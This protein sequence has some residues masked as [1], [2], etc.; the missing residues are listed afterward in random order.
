VILATAATC[1]AC[2]TEVGY[3]EL[4]VPPLRVAFVQAS[5]GVDPFGRP[6]TD[7][8]DVGASP[9][10]LTTTRIELG[11]DRFLL[12]GSV[13]R[14]AVCLRS[15]PEPVVAYE[16]CTNAETLRPS[17]DPVRRIARFHLGDADERLAPDTLYT[18]TVFAAGSG[19]RPGFRALDGTPLDADLVFRFRTAAEDPARAVEAPDQESGYCPDEA[20]VRRCASIPLCLARCSKGAREVLRTRCSSSSCHGASGVTEPAM[21]LVLGDDEG[22]RATAIGQVAHQTKLGSDAAMPEASPTRFGA[23]M[24]I[25]APRDPGSSYLLYKVLLAADLHGQ[26]APLASGE[27]ERLTSFVVGMPMPLEPG[28]LTLEEADV[29]SRWIG[30]GAPV[31]TCP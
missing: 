22:V 1:A 4:D 19:D 28:G 8:V 5:V 29:L 2:D 10:V 27:L 25:V 23:S 14:Q 30:A 6:T 9:R 7:R 21:G 15:D 16:E 20:C 26:G 3:A 18:L 24:R 11:F 13:T 12:P 17:Y 31:E